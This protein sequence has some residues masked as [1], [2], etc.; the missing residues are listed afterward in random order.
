MAYFLGMYVCMYVYGAV[1][2]WTHQ[3]VDAKWNINN[4]KDDSIIITLGIVSV[5]LCTYLSFVLR[6]NMIVRDFVLV[7]TF[8]IPLCVRSVNMA[9]DRMRC[10]DA[11]PLI[12]R[13]DNVS[14]NIGETVGLVCIVQ[15]AVAFNVT[16]FRR[17]NTRNQ[18]RLAIHNGTA[19][20][21]SFASLIVVIVK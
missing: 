19:V 15:S 9:S 5:I 16:W 10:W 18:H 20:V 12:V 7:V 2:S 17:F 13:A 8:V 1:C 6:L 4:W 21:R 3:D 14:V 11:P